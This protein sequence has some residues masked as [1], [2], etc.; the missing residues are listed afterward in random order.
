MGLLRVLAIAAVVFVAL[1]LLKR[2]LSSGKSTP[3][4]RA[5]APKLVQCAHCGIHVGES[6]AVRAGDRYY[7][8][9]EH[10]RLGE[11]PQG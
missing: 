7:C 2:V 8:S 9:A 11:P 6:D 4:P 5:P 10:R 1:M 3:T